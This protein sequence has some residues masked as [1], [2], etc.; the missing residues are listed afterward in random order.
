MLEKR[1]RVARGQEMADLVLKNGTIVNVFTGELETGDVAVCEGVIV[2][3]GSY[4]GILEVDCTDKY[5]APGFIDGHIH[6]ESR[7]A[8]SRTILL[9]LFF[10]MERRLLLRILMRLPTY[11]DERGLT[12]C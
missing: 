5:I 7:Y 8:C 9:A 10:R 6:L 3:I 2:G 1:I 11:A 12:I 4:H